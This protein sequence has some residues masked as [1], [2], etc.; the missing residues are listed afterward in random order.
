[1]LLYHSSRVSVQ[2]VM[3]CM[4]AGHVGVIQ[5]LLRRGFHLADF[6]NADDVENLLMMSDHLH[7]VSSL[8][9]DQNH[10]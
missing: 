7:H 10:V 2:T 4:N 6:D 3:S 8:H 5:Q 9:V 1:M